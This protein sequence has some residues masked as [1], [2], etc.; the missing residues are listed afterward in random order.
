MS[1]NEICGA[2]KNQRVYDDY[3]RIFK[4]CQICAAKKSAQYYEKLRD[5][6]IVKS[7]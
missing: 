2:C 5:T 6:L 1:E 4:P 7:K 3:H